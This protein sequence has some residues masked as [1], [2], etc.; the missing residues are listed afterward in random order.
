MDVESGLK[1]GV[2]PKC[3]QTEI[4]YTEADFHK[5]LPQNFIG[6]GGLG[7]RPIVDNFVCGTCG[8]TEFYI[9]PSGLKMVK[10]QWSR[11]QPD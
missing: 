7:E 6:Y 5:I 4:Y 10:N 8:Y 2:C 11:R 3:H 1:D 9:R